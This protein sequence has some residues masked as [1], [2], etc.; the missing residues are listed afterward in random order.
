MP[1]DLQQ[2]SANGRVRCEAASQKNGVNPIIV[3]DIGLIYCLTVDNGGKR[4]PPHYSILPTLVGPGIQTG[5]VFHKRSRNQPFLV[6]QILNDK[7]RLCMVYLSNKHHIVSGL[8]KGILKS[9]WWFGTCF[10]FP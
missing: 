3:V 2:A 8:K 5:W 4:I 10:I 7:H 9:D 6:L 1:K